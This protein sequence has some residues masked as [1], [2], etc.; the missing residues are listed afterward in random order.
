[1]SC[2]F[3]RMQLLRDVQVSQPRHST[4]EQVVS[5]RLKRPIRLAIPILGLLGLFVAVFSGAF[6]P[7]HAA[8]L[9]EHD[10]GAATFAVFD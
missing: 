6:G 5:P 3:A 4:D 2:I 1:M 7:V 9:E 8:F 10:G